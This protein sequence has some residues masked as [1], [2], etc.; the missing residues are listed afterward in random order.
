MRHRCCEPAEL[1]DTVHAKYVLVLILFLLSNLQS[2][3]QNIDAIQC[4][5][6]RK[7]VQ[8][9][10]DMYTRCFEFDGQGKLYLFCLLGNMYLL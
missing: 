5:S 6:G 8:R 7:S 9:I 10:N 4:T 1:W 2:G 3:V